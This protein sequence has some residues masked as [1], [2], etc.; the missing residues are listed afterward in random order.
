M[1]VLSG[2]LALYVSPLGSD[3]NDGLT[4]QT[5]FKTRN[6]AVSSLLNTN[7]NGWKV[8]I[9]L[10]CLGA[11]GI[12]TDSFQWYGPQLVGQVGPGAIEF[13]GDPQNPLSCIIVPTAGYAFGAAYGFSFTV[14][15]CIMDTSAAGA[16]IISMGQGSYCRLGDVAFGSA[17]AG[18]YNMISAAFSANVTVE[19]SEAGFVV[20][21]GVTIPAAPTIRIYGNAQAFVLAG[22][23]ASVYFNTDG[24]P[25]LI[26]V[27]LN[28]GHPTF[29]EAFLAATGGGTI[30]AERLRYVHGAHGRPYSVKNGGG[31][32]SRTQLPGDQ[33]A[34]HETWTGGWY[35]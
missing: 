20:V 26:E 31:I 22:D 1:Q 19:H 4:P 6:R 12:H 33:E 25:N 34:I 18:P 32:T 24:I 11:Q 16:D 9:H 5:A 7:L 8:T 27:W 35:V 15:G 2:P 30:N 14:K 3:F 10:A 21:D 29:V 17:G 23:N 13:R 28:H